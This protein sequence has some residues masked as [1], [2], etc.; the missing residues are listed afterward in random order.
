MGSN[1]LVIC[2]IAGILL[3]FLV[4]VIFPWDRYVTLM[5]GLVGGLAVGYFLDKRD[6]DQGRADSARV[7]NKK[8]AAANRLLERA[9]AELDG[10]EPAADDE[11][12]EGGDLYEEEDPMEPPH[13]YE[14]EA[15]EQ[16]Q[17]LNE[18]E[19]LLRKARERMKK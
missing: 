7:V 11:E 1:K 2:C 10:T 16:E 15:R 3:G 6:E 18:A 8:A 17:K 14:A 4:P 12:T 13:D 19:D 5:I 9:R